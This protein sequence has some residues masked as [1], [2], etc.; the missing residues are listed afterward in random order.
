[1]RRQWMFGLA[2]LVFLTAGS[3]RAQTLEQPRARQ[4]YWI[5]VGLVEVV[6]HVTD[7]GR[8]RG[9]YTGQGASFRIGQLLTER[10]GLA[11]LVETASFKKASDK[12]RIGGLT[13]EG[14]ATVWRGLSAHIGVGL[15][16]ESLTDQSSNDKSLRGGYGS[17]FLLGASYDFF[18]WH[19]RLSGGWAVTP[20]VDFHAAPD[21]NVHA[22]S[23]FFGLQGV[24]W[25]GLARSMLI[26]PEE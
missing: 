9:T 10:L 8:N 26:L 23:L 14:S 21:G 11:L 2:L 7:E 18:P 17:N 3:V 4:G 20:T 16:Y 13:L 24:W 5:G 6:S 12:G 25:S 1:M 22:Y 15:G 19:R